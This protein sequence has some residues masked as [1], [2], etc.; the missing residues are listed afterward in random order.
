[1]A[2]LDK[3]TFI[4]SLKEMTILEIKELVD[5]MKEEFGIDPTAVAAAP[6]GGA[7]EAA[8]EQTEFDVVLANA[9]A[10]KIAVIKV[11][12][13]ITGLG[14]ME[15]KAIVEGAPKAVKEKVSKAEAEDLKAKLEAAGAA[16]EIK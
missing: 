13:E 3:V 2:K 12:K 1:M 9:G 14:L 10:Q 4:E 5:A 11:V 6:A 15:A 8:A 16:V 7:A